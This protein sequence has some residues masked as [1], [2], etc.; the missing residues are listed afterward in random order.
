M[1]GGSQDRHALF[2][3]Q[4]QPPSVQVLR[5]RSAAQTAVN[6]TGWQNPAPANVTWNCTA[7]CSTENA[8]PVPWAVS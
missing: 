4:Q 6:F 8:S 5:D 7:N 2:A 1:Q 3:Q